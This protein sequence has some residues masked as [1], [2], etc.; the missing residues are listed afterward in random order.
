MVLE[1]IYRTF[2]PKTKYIPC[3]QHLIVPSPKLVIKHAST[4]TKILK[5]SHASY[6]HC[7]RLIF[8]NNMNNR[9]PTCM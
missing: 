3:S 7:L 8:N 4:D 9:K 2:Y 6:H 1:Y 5:K